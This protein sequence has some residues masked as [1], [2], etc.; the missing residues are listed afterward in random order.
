MLP[1]DLSS[2]SYT[3]SRQFEA[4]HSE[5]EIIAKWKTDFPSDVSGIASQAN[6]HLIYN[7]PTIKTYLVSWHLRTWVHFLSRREIRTNNYI[8]LQFLK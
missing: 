7:D 3:P 4:L 6:K 5:A 2:L 1:K 8:L